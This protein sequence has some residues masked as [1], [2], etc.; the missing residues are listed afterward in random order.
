M[1]STCVLASAGL[2]PP[3]SG[4]HCCCPACAHQAV[5]DALVLIRTG[6]A[7]PARRILEALE[8]DL[9]EAALLTRLWATMVAGKPDLK[10]QRG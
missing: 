7:L 8:K 5:A 3:P 1:K 6:R 4:R 10:P 2:P 9:S